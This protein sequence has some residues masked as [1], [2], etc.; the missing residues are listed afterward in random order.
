VVGLRNINLGAYVDSGAVLTTLD[1]LETV[2]LEF[3]IPERYFS[4]VKRVRPWP[5]PA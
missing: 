3:R 1:H 5:L 4:A 2:E